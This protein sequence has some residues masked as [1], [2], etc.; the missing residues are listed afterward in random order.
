MK[1]IIGLLALFFSLSITAQKLDKSWNKVYEYEYDGKIKSASDELNKIYKKA[2]KQNDQAEI[3][4]TFI[5][6]S[7]FLMTLE[8]EAQYKI[9][10]NLREELTTKDEVNKAIFNYIYG[11][12]LS[13]YY[14]QN[15]YKLKNQTA[16]ESVF[17][18]D[19]R[20]WSASDFE[21]EI[22]AA[23]EN[24]IKNETILLKTP[25]SNYDKIIVFG[26]F[27][28]PINRSLYDFLSEKYLEKKGFY[29]DESQEEKNFL[30]KNILSFYGEPKEFQEIDLKTYQSSPFYHRLA[31]YQK[32]EKSYASQNNA[33]AL[34]NIILKRIQTVYKK[35]N[36]LEEYLTVLDRFIANTQ[37]K[38][39]SVFLIEKARIYQDNASKNTHT[40]YNSKAVEICDLVILKGDEPFVYEAKNI[41]VSILAKSLT[42]QTDKYIIP[43]QPNLALIKF[44]CIDTIYGSL[45][46][47]PLKFAAKFE[48]GN[49]EKDSIFIDFVNKNKPYKTFKN[50][51]PDTKGYFEY[52]TE[53]ILPEMEAGVYLLTISTKK[54]NL[55]AEA[56]YSYATINATDLTL[57][58]SGSN[59]TERFQVL[60]RKT[61]K[62]IEDV[63]IKSDDFITK[64][65]KNGMARYERTKAAQNYSQNIQAI[66]A[67]DT[68]SLFYNTTY[69][70]EHA[71]TKEEEKEEK[72]NF[73][74]K[75][76]L[77]TDRSIY[78]PGQT[79]YFKGILLKRKDS[80]NDIV[81]DMF[82]SVRAENVNGEDIYMARL[83]TNEFGSFIGEF[84]IPKNTLTGDF[85][86]YAEEDEDY[87]TDAHY[88]EKTDKHPFWDKINRFEH[89]E[90]S[91]RVEE[92]KR[93]KFEVTFE[94]I[95]ESYIVNQNIK[96][97]GKAKAFAGA[98]I[99][100]GTVSY[101]VKRNSYYNNWQYSNNHF[102]YDDKEIAAGTIET[103]EDGNFEIEFTAIPAED[104]SE[105][106][107]PVFNFSI[108]AEVT[109]INGETRK[110]TTVAKAGY[111]DLVLFANISEM[112]NA[113]T[114]QKITLD[115]QNLNGQFIPIIGELK[116]YKSKSPDRV[117]SSR[118]WE[119]PEIQI[120]PEDEFMRLFP[121]LPYRDNKTTE[122]GDL[123]FSQKV[124][125][126]TTKE[127]T[128]K[129][130]KKWTSGA[131]QLFFTSKDI[132]GK[133]I[134][135]SS[136]F[137]LL[138]DSD[139][140][141]GDYELFQYQILNEDPKKDGF[142]EVQYTSAAPLYIMT[143]AFYQSK[144]VFNKVIEV[145]GKK[146]FR[147]PIEKDWKTDVKISMNFIW[148]NKNFEKKH[149]QLF[150]I[151]Q[152]KINIE[153]GTFRNK[154]EPGGNE[155]WSFFI[156]DQ[157]EKDRKAEVL[158]S[159]YDASLDQFY[160]SAWNTSLDFSND[161][162]NNI[163]FKQ[164]LGIGNLTSLYFRNL[165]PYEKPVYY[166]R[167]Q[168]NWFGF[169]F[170]HL[171]QKD[172][173]YH[174]YLT[175]KLI[176]SS[177]KTISG[178]ITENGLPIPGV[179]V[180][181]SGTDRGTQTDFDGKYEI[182]AL[183]NEILEVHFIG[184]KSRYIRVNNKTI[185]I[186]MTFSEEMLREVIVTAYAST[187]RAKSLAAVN[188]DTIEERSNA[189][190]IQN[191]QGMVF[192]MEITS[193][194]GEPGDDTIIFLRGNGSINS[195]KASLFIVDGV[196]VGEDEYRSIDLKDIISANFLKGNEATSL[197]GS[198]ASN[199]VVIITTK[200]SLE[201]LT[202]VKARKNLSETAFFFPQ[203]QTDGKGNLKFS[204]TSPEALTQWK[205]RLFA[206]TKKA[207][208]GYLE[209]FIITQKDLMVLPNVPR[210]LRE[211]DTIVIT[212]K[213]SNITSDPKSG[214]AML[215]L[216]DAV[217]M[218]PMD[219]KMLN[220]DNVKNFNIKANGNTTVS[221]KLFVPQGLQGLQY[222]ILAKAGDFT[223]GEE[224]I[225]PVLTNTMLV[226]ESIP[227]WIPGNTKKEYVFENFKNNQS[228][229][230]RNHLLTLEYTSNPA[231]YAIKSLPYLM[232]Y[233][234]ECAEQVFSRYYANTLANEIITGNPKI[235][236]V[237]DAWKKAGNPISKLEQNEELKS[238]ILAETP[239]AK[240][241][242]NEEQQKKNLAL[243]FDLEKMKTDI[244][245]NFE[246]LDRKQ[247]PSGGFPWFSGGNNNE[248]ITRHIVT[249]LGHLE[250]LKI[251]NQNIEKFRR[252]TAK[253]IPFIDEK[254]LA[255]NKN[256]EINQ[257]KNKIWNYD[258]YSDLHYLY[259]RSFYTN[260]YPVNDSLQ[261]AILKHLDYAKKHWMEYG[262]YQ[263]AMATL[264]LNRFGEKETAKKIIT[265]LKETAINNEENGMY[266]L[267][268]KAGWY[269]YQ[270]PVETQALLIEA[271]SEI[272]DEKKSVEAMKVWLLKNR[273]TKSWNT[274]K[275]T[276][277]AIYALLLHGEDWLS[278]KDN[279]VIKLGDEKIV[280]KKLAQNEKE[281]ESG[282]IKMSWKADEI[283]KDM[284]AISINNKSS[285]PGYGGFY[286]QYF[287]DLDKIK[288]SQDSPLSIEKELYIKGNTD[289]GKEL[290]KITN[291]KALKVGDLVTVRLVIYAKDDMD[292]IHLKDM[293]AAAFEP[294][295]VLSEYKWQGGLGYYM[296]TK[297]A[298]THFFFDNISKGKYVLEYDIRVNNPGELSNGITTIQ[299][300][301][302]PEFS[303]HSKGIRVKIEE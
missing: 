250:K 274:T 62:P 27:E 224:N 188:F 295:D 206:H 83:K 26:K 146:I 283:T 111:H 137:K 302:A 86:I 215:Q 93:P 124:D 246:K 112:I 106:G 53:I 209:N 263:K 214:I 107:Q 204:F 155:S 197:Y 115:S 34:S 205:L 89:S 178:V 12:L 251:S 241:T 101:T 84:I 276:T 279:T 243:L 47:I 268:N 217:T 4:R 237:F 287:E 161:N 235:A 298:A 171:E 284:S 229:T 290:Q 196:P 175:D 225:L 70:Y 52:S 138:N 97:K 260:T 238:L 3:I 183:M 116:I 66:K 212:S 184:M 18:P 75:V 165:F 269:W 9:I 76:N 20:T 152:E 158:A 73:R 131:Y 55:S 227:L 291:K 130:L 221:W 38:Y 42:I 261:K 6:Q 265:S 280:T 64:T 257:K 277:E 122:K 267:N 166:S 153:T 230:L 173:Q 120:I 32:L 159:M 71:R 174:Q 239:W 199:G 245:D 114:I 117:L 278:V 219:A 172:S 100:D 69:F 149:T 266:W 185:N 181:I 189:S 15:R 39:Q 248:Y 28:T 202:E 182:K 190:A 162:Y 11:K 233:E 126:K 211:N 285:I 210:F 195:G 41:K 296:S 36:I 220:S 164:F 142:I 289:K 187:K 99:S 228:A 157:H 29:K 264:V 139:K 282:Y 299:S 17:N 1:K 105:E 81:P 132:S 7:K 262:L 270:A 255:R 258:I 301:Y 272:G 223:D 186:E 177:G 5:Y 253:A 96:V 80:K 147:I 35:R 30:S 60:N 13:E 273:Q 136:G 148:E 92:Y 134:E 213:I 201:A 286:W 108:E 169:D 300:M 113:K 135:V 129:D 67:K 252:I 102:S 40:D 297:D 46:K 50:R 125:T 216:F 192:G 95:T 85:T 194:K 16:T 68:L 56:I 168:F 145:N 293:R 22:T 163:E 240:D 33:N 167:S 123:I 226:T 160:E 8:E 150:P 203:L 294:V 303:S 104:F 110:N 25:L 208:S 78:R 234:H 176:L 200:K 103:D 231:W 127:I 21:K 247:S 87:E 281:A 51:L 236:A 121:T 254:F 198:R 48:S 143:E 109:D 119:A 63:V 23:Y 19:F 45:H 43:N 65:D 118:R 141:P 151:Y 249:G 156:K 77:F 61:G 10:K 292:F 154:I 259:A 82:V 72:E 98:A 88:N 58:Y 179:S 140:V 90:I 2:R 191:L 256:A 207:V 74:V 14:S 244:N 133:E 193:G 288:S 79:V 170:L 24:S 271:F 31:I 49:I 128:L 44:A 94:P 59:N 222:K 180:K 57:A 91:F 218:E 54:D 275:A 232:E 37:N 144:V 242:E